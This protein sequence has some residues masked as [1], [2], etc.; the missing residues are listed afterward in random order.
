LADAIAVAH[1]NEKKAD[2]RKQKMEKMEKKKRTEIEM[3]MGKE[4]KRKKS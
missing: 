1:K 2:S 3:R 4:S